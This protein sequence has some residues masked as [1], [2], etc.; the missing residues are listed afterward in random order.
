MPTASHNSGDLFAIG[1]DTVVYSFTDADSNSSVCSFMVMISDLES[2]TISDCPANINSCSPVTAFIPPTATDNC[3]LTS[4][5]K[6]VTETVSFASILHDFEYVAVDDAGND[7]T[8]AF[9]IT[10]FP[11]PTANA[12]NDAT[13]TEGDSVTIGGSPAGFG[14]YPITS[15]I[16]NPS[17]GLDNPNAPNPWADPTSTTS[18][19]LFAI[20]DNGCA[21]TDI[22]T[23]TVSPA[24]GNEGSEKIGEV[25]FEVT[26]W[27]NP[28]RG[29]LNVQVSRITQARSRELGATVLDLVEISLVDILGREV[30]HVKTE[31]GDGFVWTIDTS[32]LAKGQYILTAQSN[33][34]INHKKIIMLE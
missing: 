17:E 7:D 8:C 21:A 30:H 5:D 2:P 32:G 13:I 4:F 16:W 24:F 23:V 27:P 12:G 20:D 1:I 10:Q 15:Y 14:F 9:T 25:D 3:N 31:L 29:V 34:S 6:F 11:L 18:Y 28:V 26:T 33:N 19:L 22:M